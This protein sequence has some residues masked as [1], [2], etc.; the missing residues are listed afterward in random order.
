MFWYTILSAID[1]IFFTLVRDSFKIILYLADVEI[2]SETVISD[3]S[4]RVYMLLAVI[5][6]FK[7]AVSTIQYLVDPD[8]LSD[9]NSGVASI[10]KNSA[11]AI[12]L[13]VVVPE[14]FRFARTAQTEV[15]SYIPALIMGDEYGTVT[16][17]SNVERVRK[18]ADDMTSTIMRIFYTPKTNKS[19]DQFHYGK[20][21]NLKTFREQVVNDGCAKFDIWNLGEYFSTESCAWNYTII[22][23]VVVAILMLFVLVSMA[24]DIA[25]RA[26][27]FALLEIMAP[28]PIVSYIDKGGKGAF[29]SW[30]KEVKDVYIDLFIRIAVVYF[31]IFV[32][33]KLVLNFN[34][35]VMFKHM[36]GEDLLVKGLVLVFIIV[37]LL[38]FG[39]EAPKYLCDALGI[40]GTDKISPMFKRAG[41]LLGTALGGGRD[42]IAGARNK[43]NKLKSDSNFYDQEHNKFKKGKAL[44]AAFASAGSAARSGFASNRAGLRSAL[45]GKGFKETMEASRRASDRA[46]DLHEARKDAHVSWGQ[47]QR[48]VLKNRMGI[49]QDLEAINAEIKAAQESSDKAKASLDWVHNNLG[50]KLASLQFGNDF[51]SRDDIKDKIASSALKGN[52]VIGVSSTGE[53]MVMNM[54]QMAEGGSST[55]NSVMTRLKATIED[56]NGDVARNLSNKRQAEAKAKEEEAIAEE[57][58]RTGTKISDADK[59]KRIA[60]KQSEAA[61]AAEMEADK[62]KSDA[63][64]MMDDLQGF[65]DQFA[66]SVAGMKDSKETKAYRDRVGYT[67]NPAFERLIEEAK[68]AIVT[69]SSTSF[70]INTAE[71]GKARGILD[72]DGKVIEGMLGDWIALNKKKGQ[73]AQTANLATSQSKGAEAAAKQIAD[74]Y[75][76]KS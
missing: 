18:Q 7:I 65:V 15:A 63:Q 40:K 37:G 27:K 57:E 14:V 47:Y 67:G 13:L 61:T 26:I 44:R 2:F 21:I 55:I 43:L 31:I 49:R 76:K 56:S 4:K 16:G 59:Q 24:V 12:I 48:E 3:F 72:A 46:Y 11:I 34:G 68:T 39:K 8:K 36:E 28:I 50:A 33:D 10:L 22:L 41:G 32:I 73:D 51:L 71:E 6:F 58:R 5:M 75:D 52:F 45:G 19:D 25:I 64:K 17:S 66:V 30:L 9:S 60:K 38:L 74:K 62:I 69:H 20:V 29:E 54:S 53:K 70:G 23:P 35:G 1:N 42:T